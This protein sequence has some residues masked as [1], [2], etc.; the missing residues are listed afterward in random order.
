MVSGLS[1]EQRPPADVV[2]R[3]EKKEMQSVLRSKGTGVGCPFFLSPFPLQYLRFSVSI[4]GYDTSVVTADVKK[5]K[6]GQ[7]SRL[8]NEKVYTTSAILTHILFVMSRVQERWL[9]VTHLL[10]E[11]SP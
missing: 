1:S 3:P 6:A 9:P 5:I 7:Q 4:Y 11:A 8:M 10:Q 2:S